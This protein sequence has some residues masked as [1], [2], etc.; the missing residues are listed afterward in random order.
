MN[1]SHFVNH[2][3]YH[4]LQ[5][6]TDIFSCQLRLLL[7]KT[8][9][10]GVEEVRLEVT[11]VIFSYQFNHGGGLNNCDVL[12]SNAG[13]ISFPYLLVKTLVDSGRG[14]CPWGIQLICNW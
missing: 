2:L 8:I 6:G 1:N 5:G 11:R 10:E 4:L 12:D 9:L 14:G 13:K 7:D 3:L